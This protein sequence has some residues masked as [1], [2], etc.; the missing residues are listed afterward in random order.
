MT[1][2]KQ[3]VIEYTD[4]IA[5]AEC[6]FFYV[7]FQD[8]LSLVEAI[9]TCHLNEW[10]Y[11]VWLKNALGNAMIDLYQK[12]FADVT[13]K[14]QSGL[15]LLVN[16]FNYEELNEATERYKNAQRKFFKDLKMNVD[17]DNVIEIHKRTIRDRALLDLIAEYSEYIPGDDAKFKGDYA[18]MKQLADALSTDHEAWHSLCSANKNL[19]DNI[20]GRPLKAKDVPR[21]CLGIT[22]DA[23]KHLWAEFRASM[24][25]EKQSLDNNI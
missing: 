10:D 15:K 22:Y 24:L 14:D 23:M 20:N 9:A 19:S 13:V 21:E 11:P 12:T 6:E 5:L 3:T 4:P 7:H 2:N 17:R 16:S 1:N 8:G 25:K 18:V